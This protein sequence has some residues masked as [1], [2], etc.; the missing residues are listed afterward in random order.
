MQFNSLEFPIFL[1]IVFTIYWLLGKRKLQNPFLLFASYVFYGFWNWQLLWL[2]AAST[3]LDYCIAIAIAKSDVRIR[4]KLLLAL[5]LLCNI[6]LLGY[7][8]YA[9]FFLDS[10]KTLF[11]SIGISWNTETLS[12]ILPI[13]ISFYTF[14]SLSY[15][16][17]TYKGKITPTNSFIDF[18]AYISFFPQLVAGPIERARI[19]LPQFQKERS[20][21]TN[22]A[23]D[24]T[25]QFLWGMMKKVSIA[26]NCAIYVDYIF[27]NSAQLSAPELAIGA[28][29]FTIQIYCDFSGYSDMALGLAK[30]FGFR[31]SINFNYPLF[32]TSV[33]EFW[34]RWHISLTNWFRDYL[35]YPMGGNKYGFLR[36]LR[37]IMITFLVSG[38]WHGANWTFIVWGAANAL[39]F[40]PSLFTKF[41]IGISS[42]LK[43]S[44]NLYLNIISRVKTFLLISLA[45]VF[46]R[47]SDVSSGFQ[48]ISELLILEDYLVF[49]GYL[50][51]VPIFLL[52]SVLFIIE[53][54]SREKE[55]ALSFIPNKKVELAM[56]TLTIIMIFTLARVGFT[57]IYFQF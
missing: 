51:F 15:T 47:S 43:G 53:W 8:K 32:S 41:G 40:L 14:Q 21:D 37:N 28:I 4:S 38:L 20:F 57:F 48:F 42:K 49:S 39:F 9:N 1:I 56:V 2:I 16:F 29:L 27:E 23:L 18:A 52:T 7:F 25:K 54:F 55:H 34:R 10:L 24:G 6:G 13:G 26:D 46:F 33:A 35:Y 45:F 22:T 31:L 36:T 12:I 3:F 11:F 30:L 44:N 50:K 19:L 17:D 5:S